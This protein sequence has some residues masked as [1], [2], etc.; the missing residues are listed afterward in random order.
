MQVLSAFVVTSFITLCLSLAHEVIT[1][2]G[3]NKGYWIDVTF[4]QLFEIGL[5]A[6]FKER[7]T[8]E[9]R[10]KLR[11]VLE[12]VILSL[13]DQQILV[14]LAMLLAGII[15]MCSIS[16]YHFTIVSDLGWFASNTHLITLSV[17]QSHFRLPQHHVQRDWRVVLILLIFAF[18]VTYQILQANG[19]W[20]DNYSSHAKCLFDDLIGNVYGPPAVGMEVNLF[21][22]MTSY[23]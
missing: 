22:L 12:A 23:L 19:Y 6:I 4:G 1:L 16:A 21:L 10:Q 11:S 18:L 2:H 5:Q 7:L 8:D 9:R 17:L 20:Y 13:S 15:R 14:G 3:E